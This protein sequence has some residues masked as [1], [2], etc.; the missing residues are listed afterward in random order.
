MGAAVRGGCCC[1]SCFHFRYSQDRPV[2]SGLG[3]TPHRRTAPPPESTS[4]SLDTGWPGRTR[5]PR[6]G[7]R[8]TGVPPP[9]PHPPTL[10]KAAAPK[11]PC[12]CR[13]LAGLAGPP[14]RTGRCRS[15]RSLGRGH[16]AKRPW[17]RRPAPLA[18]PRHGGHQGPEPRL[19]VPDPQGT[20]H[21]RSVPLAVPGAAHVARDSSAPCVGR[22][23]GP[24]PDSAATP[25][26]LHPGRGS[27]GLTGS[28]RSSA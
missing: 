5:D 13:C 15:P 3:S 11:G 8:D 6:T 14:V 25:T 26:S 23:E 2:L 7:H 28:P 27:A 16:A 10:A 1:C 19:P 4:R 18:P 20:G 21:Q 9:H 12:R 17:A 24:S 22:M